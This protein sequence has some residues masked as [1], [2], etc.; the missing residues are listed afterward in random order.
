MD[1]MLVNHEIRLHVTTNSYCC[2]LLLLLFQYFPNK[3]SRVK[4]HKVLPTLQRDE[5][6]H[7]RKFKKF[8][9]LD[10]RLRSKQSQYIILLLMAPQ[11][12]ERASHQK[13]SLLS[14]KPK[15]SAQVNRRYLS[16]RHP[17]ILLY[18]IAFCLQ[19]PQKEE[20]ASHPNRSLLSDKPEWRA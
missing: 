2:K 1:G 4:F 20:R 14:S 12:W 17:S 19:P 8:N 7:Y 15:Q 5:S 10:R 9:F 13:T 18:H 11:K 16:R 3:A 6:V